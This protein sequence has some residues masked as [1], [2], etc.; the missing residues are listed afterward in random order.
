MELAKFENLEVLLLKGMNKMNKIK[1]NMN[2]IKN[3]HE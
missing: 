1:T 2:K 3:K